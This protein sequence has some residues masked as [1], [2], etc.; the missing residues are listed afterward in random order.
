MRTQPVGRIQ[1]RAVEPV[2]HREAAA[3]EVVDVAVPEG[4]LPATV[5]AVAHAVAVGIGLAAILVDH[6]ALLGVHAVVDPVENAVT[7][8]VNGG[9]AIARG[10]GVDVGGPRGLRLC[11]HPG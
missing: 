6:A 2:V 10:L 11:P 8:E 3:A 5:T 1:V 4:D 9:P 7:I